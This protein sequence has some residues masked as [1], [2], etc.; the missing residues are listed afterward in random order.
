MLYYHIYRVFLGMQS[1]LKQ[2]MSLPC[3]APHRWLAGAHQASVRR[4]AWT[5][6]STGSP[7][8]ID[9]SRWSL[10]GLNQQA[11]FEKGTEEKH[12]LKTRIKYEGD[13]QIDANTCKN[14]QVWGLERTEYFC[15]TSENLKA[16]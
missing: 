12:I 7:C 13:L 1:Y 14:D 3:P 2:M 8:Y 15:Y 9:A 11:E 6:S 10:P 5:G 16:T 4:Q